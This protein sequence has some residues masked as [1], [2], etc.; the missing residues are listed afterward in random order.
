LFWQLQLELVKNRL[1][2]LIKL[3][4][5]PQPNLSTLYGGEY[6]IHAM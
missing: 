1:L 6:D 3:G 4:D 2:I 5:A